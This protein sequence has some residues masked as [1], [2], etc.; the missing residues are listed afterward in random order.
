M[1]I[2]YGHQYSS[3]ST[4]NNWSKDITLRQYIMSRFSDALR[5]FS[6][7]EKNDFWDIQSN[8][9]PST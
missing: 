7:I 1:N 5:L 8:N 3:Y 9:Y 4:L 2:N 6:I